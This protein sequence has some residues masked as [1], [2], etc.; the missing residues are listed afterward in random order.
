MTALDKYV[1]RILA[2]VRDQPS[3]WAVGTVAT[4]SNATTPPTVTVN[5]NGATVPARCSRQVTPVV[6]HT[7]LMARVGPQLLIVATY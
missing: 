6:G 2:A 1:D 4:V 5:W 7:A 3:P